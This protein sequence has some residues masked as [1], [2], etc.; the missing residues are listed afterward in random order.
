MYRL[1][2]SEASAPVTVSAQQG[3]VN[4]RHHCKNHNMPCDLR[5]L[6]FESETDDTRA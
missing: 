4:S 6:H 3:F 2:F 5:R 1:E